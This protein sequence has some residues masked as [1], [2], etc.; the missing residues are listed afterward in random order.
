MG[1]TP[2]AGTATRQTSPP[3]GR[4]EGPC[5][6]ALASPFRVRL[7]SAG[8]SAAA[9]VGPELWTATPQPKARHLRRSVS[10]DRQSPSEDEKALA[11]AVPAGSPTSKVVPTAPLHS[12][13]L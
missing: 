3:G 13:P 6:A 11:A 9:A 5:A 2:R 7:Q 12:R 4:P 10:T 8:R 1:G